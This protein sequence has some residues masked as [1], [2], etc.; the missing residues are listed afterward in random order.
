[1]KFLCLTCDAQMK[2]VENRRQM[3]EG[4]MAIVLECPECFGQVGMLTN[5]ME[6]KLLDSLDVSVCPV[7][8]K[9][10][11]PASVDASAAGSAPAAPAWSA[12]AEA[13]LAVI[14]SFARAAARHGIEA[15]AREHGH[16]L[17]TGAV[18]DAAR[19]RVGL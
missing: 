8:G 19:A 5:P 16:E 17:I 12:E 18:L 9:G 13:R 3:G 6:T 7:G 2:T 11:Q 1:M 14:P 4:S 15:F 10:R